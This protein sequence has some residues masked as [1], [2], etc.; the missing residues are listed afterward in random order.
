MTKLPM[1]SIY[2]GCTGEWGGVP[3]APR[4]EKMK[5]S[6]KYSSFNGEDDDAGLFRVV[7]RLFTLRKKGTRAVTG[8]VPCKESTTLS[9][10]YP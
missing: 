1:I 7:A 5:K 3:K 4:L 9:I 8:V 2:T 6:C 10:I